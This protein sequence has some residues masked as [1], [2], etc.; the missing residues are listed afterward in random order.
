MT[1]TYLYGT[2]A[3]HLLSSRSSFRNPEGTKEK[4]VLGCGAGEEDVGG[5]PRLKLL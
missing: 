4:V 1:I 2:R 3:T 5:G